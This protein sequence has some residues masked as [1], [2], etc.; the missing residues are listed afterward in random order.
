[1]ALENCPQCNH[2]VSEAA[3]ACRSCGHPLI[4]Q[5]KPLVSRHLRIVLQLTAAGVL[6]AEVMRSADGNISGAISM[7][8]IGLFLIFVGGGTKAQL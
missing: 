4:K 8:I 6:L 2:E 1:V 3:A 5:K 7:G